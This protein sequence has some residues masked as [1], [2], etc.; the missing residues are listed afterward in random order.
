M[1]KLSDYPETAYPSIIRH[2]IKLAGIQLELAYDIHVVEYGRSLASLK[3][4]IEIQL[5]KASN[6]TYQP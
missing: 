1:F 5:L 4:F 6:G 2:M 3:C